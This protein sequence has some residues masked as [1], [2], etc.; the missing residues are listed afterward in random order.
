MLGFIWDVD[1]DQ[2]TMWSTESYEGGFNLGKY[3]NPQVDKLLESGLTELDTAKRK[4][5]YID[6]QNAVLED[7][8]SI[9][10]VFPQGLGA[11]NKRLHNCKPNAVSIRWNTHLWWVEDGK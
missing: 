3:S 4:Q 11:V 2:T 6:M 5:I 1:P 7:A 10:L 8:P 9:I